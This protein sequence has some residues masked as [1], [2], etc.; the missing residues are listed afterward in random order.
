[1]S[2]IKVIATFVTTRILI[3]EVE[4]ETLNE[5]TKIILENNSKDE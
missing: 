2:K 3:K 4:A 1:M 5:A